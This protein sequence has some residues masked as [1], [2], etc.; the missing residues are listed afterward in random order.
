M[1]RLVLRLDD[2]HEIGKKPR[3][4]GEDLAWGIL[5]IGICAQNRPS[6]D[7]PI[8]C[9]IGSSFDTKPLVSIG[10]QQKNLNLILF[11]GGESTFTGVL[12]RIGS[13]FDTKW[14]C[15]QVMSFV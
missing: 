8:L 6:A 1:L 5:C 10:P 7:I 13:S 15:S 3:M 14:V 12:C 11:F 2:F 9:R 4:F